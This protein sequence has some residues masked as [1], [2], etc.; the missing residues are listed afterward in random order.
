MNEGDKQQQRRDDRLVHQLI[1]E[2][3]LVQNDKGKNDIEE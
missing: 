2:S 3:D 1:H